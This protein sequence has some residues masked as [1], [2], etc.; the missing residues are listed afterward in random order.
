MD[1]NYIIEKA[2]A[3]P[4]PLRAHAAKE[5]LQ[6]C[7]LLH[8][9]DAGMLEN[10]A[11]IGGTALRILHKLPRYSEDLD[12]MWV[13]PSLQFDINSWIRVIADSFRGQDVSVD[14]SKKEKE[15][16]DALVEKY[17]ATI[18]LHA[19]SNAFKPFARQ[20]LQIS[21]EIDLNPPECINRECLPMEINKEV[22]PIPTLSLPSL[23]AGKLHI[24]LTRTDREKGRDWFDYVWYRE[25]QVLPDVNQLRSAIAQ[26]SLGPDARYWTS[27]LR[28]RTQHVN[29][30]TVS[31]DVRPFLENRD[32]LKK[33]TRHNAA[34]ITPWPDFE[35]ISEE[36]PR[37]GAQH[38]IFTTA[39]PVL[40]DIRQAAL[41]GN[42][43]AIDARSAVDE[44][45]RSHPE[46]NRV[47]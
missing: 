44:V 21:I 5:A 15:K 23:M 20:G 18:Y 25:H 38:P 39:A 33:L 24:L 40:S 42:E 16:V 32:D 31:S 29:W 47:N 10:V 41:D 45:L 4:L 26:T 22:V 6:R 35:T 2:T 19:D 3:A 8:L 34:A 13:A 30:L 14:F 1:L 28:E 12:F 43:A 17:S 46:L 27:F 36:L 9:H 37:N 11:F 7:I